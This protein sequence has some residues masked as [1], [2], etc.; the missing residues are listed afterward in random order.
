MPNVTIASIGL[1]LM[2]LP[3]DTP[4]ARL[5]DNNKRCRSPTPV[6]HVTGLGD[7]A[8][9]PLLSSQHLIGLTAKA[10]YSHFIKSL[11]HEQAF[12]GVQSAF[13]D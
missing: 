6:P 2:R 1:L 13:R 10:V 12:G 4:Q 5:L 8:S 3:G 11:P 7:V 9:P